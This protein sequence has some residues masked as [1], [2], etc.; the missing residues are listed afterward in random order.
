MAHAIPGDSQLPVQY[1]RSTTIMPV[2]PVGGFV[3]PVSPVLG[4]KC[5]SPLIHKISSRASRKTGAEARASRKVAESARPSEPCGGRETERGPEEHGQ[6]QRGQGELD[7]GSA[8]TTPMSV[9]TGC[10]VRSDTS[11]LPLSRPLT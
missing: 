3:Y 6:H 2:G 4:N 1:R 5:R 9:A 10:L 11:R 7:G 8:G